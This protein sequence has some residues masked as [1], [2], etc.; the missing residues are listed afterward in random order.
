M[1][2]AA[3]HKKHVPRVQLSLVSAHPAS[4]PGAHC[5]DE[6]VALRPHLHH[7]LAHLL[8][9]HHVARLAPQLLWRSAASGGRERASRS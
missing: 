7:L 5:E 2:H 4:G 9:P 8:P 6:R 3:G 1:K